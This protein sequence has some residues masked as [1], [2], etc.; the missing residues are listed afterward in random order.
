V[1]APRFPRDEIEHAFRRYFLT[2]PVNEDWVAWSRL[3]T[4]DA[5]YTCHFWG[6]F[7]G[8]AEIQTFIEGTMSCAPQCYSALHWY[9]VDDGRVVYRVLN[10]ADDPAGGPPIE[11]PSLQ[12]VTYAGDGRWSAEEDWWILHESKAWGKRYAAAAVADPGHAARMT[13][14]DWGPW[15]DWARPAPGAHPEPSW[16]GRTDVVP[17]RSLADLTVGVRN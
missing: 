11:F 4:D 3:F 15:V 6:T 10:R 14:Q 9:A 16:V 7:H 2:G 8:P 12:V 5:V 1:T 17:V 13:R